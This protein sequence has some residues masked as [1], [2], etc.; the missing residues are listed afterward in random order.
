[1]EAD[2]ANTTGYQSLDTTEHVEAAVWNEEQTFGLLE[3][4]L[5]CTKVDY[6]LE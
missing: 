3:E 2:K 6:S 4:M 5:Y 1:M